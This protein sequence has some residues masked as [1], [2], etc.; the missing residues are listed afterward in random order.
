MKGSH[1]LWMSDWL[2]SSE[3]F[4]AALPLLD[5]CVAE[6]WVCTLLGPP[7]AVPFFF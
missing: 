1:L 6:F 7:L 4:I 5:V 2:P 3:F